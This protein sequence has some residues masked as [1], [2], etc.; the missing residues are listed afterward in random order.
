[1]YLYVAKADSEP[2]R[3]SWASLGL[4]LRG[5]GFQNPP[6]TLYLPMTGLPRRSEL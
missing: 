2:I 6:R 3:E 4:E 1:M 5:A